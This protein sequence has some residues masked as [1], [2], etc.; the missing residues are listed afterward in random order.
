MINFL[1]L[2]LVLLLLNSCNDE[3]KVKVISKLKK[4]KS[5]NLKVKKKPYKKQNI[6]VTDTLNHNNANAF[7]RAY[8]KINKETIVEFSTRLGNFTFQ[9]YKDTPIHRANFIFLAKKGYFDTTSFHRLVPNFVAQFGNS[10]RMTTIN[11]RNKYKNYRLKPEFRKNHKHFRGALAVARDWEYNPDKLSTPFEFYIVQSKKP[12]HHLNF[13]H[14]VIG[15][16]IKGMHVIDKIILEKTDKDEWPFKDID[17]KVVS[18][19]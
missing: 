19:R 14:T 13:E 7:F 3:K 1:R 10:D 18:I 5:T 6:T 15:K 11:F 9:L 2:L 4:E 16:V 17:I 8:G 12:Q